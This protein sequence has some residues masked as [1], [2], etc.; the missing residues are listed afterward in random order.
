MI[1]NQSENSNKIGGKY[2]ETQKV[3][4]GRNRKILKKTTEVKKFSR[5]SKLSQ[6]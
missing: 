2:E 6:H 3:F 4:R 5:I 1:T